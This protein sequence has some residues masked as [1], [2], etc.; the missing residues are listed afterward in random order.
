[1]HVGIPYSYRHTTENRLFRANLLPATKPLGLCLYLL[2]ETEI[3]PWAAAL[4]HLNNWKVTLQ[5]TDAIPLINQ[6]LRH[7][8]GPIYNKLG[9]E[10][11]GTHMERYF[12]AKCLAL[13]SSYSTEAG[14]IIIT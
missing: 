6:M 2:K 1:M 3:V 9:W 12:S 5:G 11:K 10:D 4:R 14:M 13:L 8:I 7:L